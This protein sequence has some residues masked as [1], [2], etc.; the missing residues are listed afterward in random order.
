M[1]APLLPSSGDASASSLAAA[2]AGL[3]GVTPARIGADPSA[4]LS[5]RKVVTAGVLSLLAAFIWGIWRGDTGTRLLAAIPRL[6]ARD[7]G[8]MRIVLAAGLLWAF[9]STGPVEP[10]LPL[11]S[12]RG[13][14]PFADW[15]WVHTLAAH[16]RASLWIH[17]GMLVAAIALGLGLFTRVAAVSVAALTTLHAL[18]LLQRQS[19]HDWGIPVVMLWL[20]VLVPWGDAVSVDAAWRR[21]RGGRPPVRAAA[22]WGLAVW[23]PGFALGIALLAAA[24]AKLDSSGLSWITSG[25]VRY[26]FVT[27]A[28]QA[29]VDWG[30]RIAAS[31]PLAQAAS[32][33]AVLIEALFFLNIFATGWA[34]RL[35]FGLAGAA[36]L[37]GFL[38]FQGVFW[39]MWWVPLLVFLPWHRLAGAAAAPQA[40][41]PPPRA[42]LRRWQIAVL[43]LFA[44]QQVV[45]SGIRLEMEPF[46]S[47]YGMYS[48]TFASTA[49]FDEYLANK[50]RTWRFEMPDSPGVDI[51]DRVDEVLSDP[52]QTVRVI[53]EEPR[54]DWQAG[55]F[56]PPARRDHGLLD[57]EGIRRLQSESP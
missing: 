21:Y 23:I 53:V 14:G 6:S 42:S 34:P 24:F 35:A 45:F 4:F 12:H 52:R 5:V 9:A 27:D 17:N 39:A 10:G 31:V 25:A 2:I 15:S 7:A 18:V 41:E 28:N 22:E 54:F 37:T 48:F 56:A 8:I 20:L 49:E 38:L 46:V 32:L 16:D 33:G 40:G 1:Q 51:E 19:A 44:L 36:L 11:A 26:H 50:R 30:L 3:L 57:A 47:D 55:R 13:G 29:P 43:G